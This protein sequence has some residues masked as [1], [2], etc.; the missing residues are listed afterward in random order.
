M[1]NE[2]AQLAADIDKALQQGTAAAWNAGQKSVNDTLARAFGNTKAGKKEIETLDKEAVAAMRQRG[3]D[4][5]TAYTQPRDGVTVSD[6]VW[7]MNES[8]KLELEVAIQNAVLEGQSADELGRTIQ[9]YL[10]HSDRLFR[11]IRVKDPAT[12]EWTGE[13]TMS[14][15]AK[16]C[17]PGQGVYR[18]SYKNALRLARTEL[19]Q[20]YRRAEWETFQDNPLIT[21]YRIELSNNHTTEVMT[22]KGRKTI[23]LK[24]ICDK[25]AGTEYPKTFLWTGWHP[26][27]RC[28]MV[29]ILVTKN[30]FKERVKARHTGKLKEWQPKEQ[31][32][33]MPKVFVEWVN[34]NKAR[35][36]ANGKA[37]PFFIRDNYKNGDVDKGLDT[38]ITAAIEE[39]KLAAATAKAK[40]KPTTPEPITEWD[41]EVM[42]LRKIESAYSLDLDKMEHLRAEGTDRAALRKEINKQQRSYQQKKGKWEQAYQEAENQLQ[43]L[44]MLLVTYQSQENTK[45]FWDLRETIIPNHQSAI[46]DYDLSYGV[47]YHH[48]VKSLKSIKERLKKI[49]LKFEEIFKTSKEAECT[50]VKDE[51]NRTLSHGVV[52]DCSVFQTKEG[53]TIIVPRDLDQEKQRIEIEKLAEAIEKLPQELKKTIKEVQVVDFENPDDKTIWKIKYKNF[54]KSFATGG[55]GIVTFYANGEQK[56]NS[57]NDEFINNQLNKSMAHETGHNLDYIKGNKIIPFSQTSVWKDA[58]MADE[59]ESGFKSVTEYGENEAKE[60]FAE[61]CMLYHTRRNYFKRTFPHRYKIIESFIAQPHQA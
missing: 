14:E 57:E 42:E 34:D 19:T 58:M 20:A 9:Q 60:D 2:V 33:E 52:R 32:T 36:Q 4:A 17:H 12:G 25:M 15:A 51:F 41:S 55:S 22:K 6:R 39:A 16:K 40:A 23:P 13:Y 3:A 56:N 21:G 35:W 31:T 26:Q 44:R 38:R 11:S 5:H 45:E 43:E 47:P 54:T 59:K 29:P 50:W 24:D 37:A 46:E 8:T 49:Y 61:S 27:C 1:Q 7:K 10:V 18:S 53:Y 28:R 30:D 48:A